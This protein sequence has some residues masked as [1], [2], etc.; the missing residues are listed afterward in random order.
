MVKKLLLLIEKGETFS[1]SFLLLFLNKVD[2]N[3]TH[4]LRTIPDEIEGKEK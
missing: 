2:T 1:F 4:K 3:K